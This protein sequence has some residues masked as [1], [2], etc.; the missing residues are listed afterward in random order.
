[1]QRTPSSLAGNPMQTWLKVTL[2]DEG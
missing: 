2:N 1:M